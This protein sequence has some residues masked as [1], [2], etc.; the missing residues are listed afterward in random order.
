MLH[1]A[2][3]LPYFQTYPYIMYNIICSII[4]AHPLIASTTYP[5]YKTLQ[6][7]ALLGGFIR[8]PHHT[9]CARWLPALAIF[10]ILEDV[11]PATIA[12]GFHTTHGLK[13]QRV[14]TLQPLRNLVSFTITY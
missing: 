2:T 8:G 10:K 1:H 11:S 3:I 4:V 7:T 6:N 9:S 5:K 13:H 12:R 14:V